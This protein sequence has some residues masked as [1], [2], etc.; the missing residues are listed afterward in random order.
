MY[1]VSCDELNAFID[2]MLIGLVRSY[3]ETASAL[4]S[5]VAYCMPCTNELLSILPIDYVFK[6]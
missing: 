1:F 6:M 2:V 5:L 4:L 3:F